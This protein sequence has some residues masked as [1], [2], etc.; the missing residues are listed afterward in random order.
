MRARENS[1]IK[2]A[3]ERQSLT[4]NDMHLTSKFVKTNGIVYSQ[5]ILD[6]VYI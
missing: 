5:V 6:S 3:G 2:F 1:L 4:N